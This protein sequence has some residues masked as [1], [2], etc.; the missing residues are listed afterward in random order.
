MTSNQI[1]FNNYLETARHN[2]ELEKIERHKADSS[3]MS[4]L[5]S[6]ISAEASARQAGVASR[7]QLEDVRH[8]REDE[9]IRQGQL[10]VQSE[11]ASI[12][13]DTQKEAV[14]HNVMAESISKQQIESTREVGLTQAAVNREVGLQQAAAAHRQAGAAESQ[15]RTAALRQSEDAR[16]NMVSEGISQIQAQA[17]VRQAGAAE[18]SA[19]GALL[20]GKS[21]MT[22]AE[23]SA[24]SAEAALIRAETE[25]GLSTS[26]KVQNYGAGFNSFVQG[27][28]KLA[29][30]IMG[31]FK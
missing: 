8:N 6:G 27:G 30:T 9:A 7:R 23:A 15:A 5:A 24:K 1:A 14:R 21:A 29:Q 22:S 2:A 20:R 16:H 25:K 3:R 19:E 28:S 18:R 12:A 10:R 4:A 26:K 11:Q 13:R 31:V 17:S